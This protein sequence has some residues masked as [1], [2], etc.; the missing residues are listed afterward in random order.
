MAISPRLILASDVHCSIPSVVS[1]ESATLTCYF[2]ENIQQGRR[3]FLVLHY[4]T[5]VTFKEI[6]YCHWFTSDENSDKPECRPKPGYEYGE[7]DNT[8]FT[9]K[10]PAAT[11][12]NVGKY[13]CQQLPSDSTR[14]K[15]CH[16]TLK[17]TVTLPLFIAVPVGVVAFLI[18]VAVV[19]CV[20]YFRRRRRNVSTVDIE[21]N[22]QQREQT[23]EDGEH[24]QPLIPR[25]EASQCDIASGETETNP[26]SSTSPSQPSA[27]GALSTESA[28]S[29][30][31]N[32]STAGEDTVKLPLLIAVPVGVLAFLISAVFWRR[33][34]VSTVDIETNSQ[35]R[36]QTKEDGEHTQ[37]LIPRN[38]ASQPDLVSGETETNPT[39]STSPSQPSAT[40]ALSTESA[41]SPSTNGSTAREDTVKLPL[42]IAVPVGVLAFL[43]SAVFWRRRNVST[44]DIETNSQQREQTKE[45]GEHTQPLIPRNEASQPDLASGETETN[46]TSSTSPSQPSA[47]RALSTESAASPSTN[48][49]TAGE[50]SSQVDSEQNANHQAYDQALKALQETGAVI[51]AGPE[52]CG[53]TTLA[54]DLLNHF[55]EEGYSTETRLRDLT[56]WNPNARDLDKKCVFIFDE[57]FKAGD[58][59]ISQHTWVHWFRILRERHCPLVIIVQTSETKEEDVQAFSFLRNI[60]VVFAVGEKTKDSASKTMTEKE[61]KPRREVWHTTVDPSGKVGRTARG[62]KAYKEGEKWEEHKLDLVIFNLQE[63]IGRGPEADENSVKKL[64]KAAG[65]SDS[66]VREVTCVTRLGEKKDWPPRPVKITVKTIETKLHIIEYARN[67]TTKVHIHPYTT[68]RKIEKQRALFGRSG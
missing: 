23:K 33:R 56:K 52:R 37:P 5:N 41:A 35:Q 55:I 36:E 27:T 64:L 65:V 28:A 67:S 21:T 30:S 10:I 34:N 3:E 54:Q 51:I 40:R 26:T 2:T 66:E 24:T 25:N 17:D 13:Q 4:L 62:V 44:V 31:T 7:L 18:C 57:V 58:K 43:I 22:S 42:L 48:G 46:P 50:D 11:E 19:V 29:P 39:S 45:D 63:N 68:E 16:L 9:L 32:G 14:T 12:E 1:G 49:S 60:P 61:G 38:E 59:T 6:I 8:T 15:S 20:W 47:T 53:K